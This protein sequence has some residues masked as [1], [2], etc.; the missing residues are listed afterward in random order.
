MPSEK[1]LLNKPLTAEE[2]ARLESYCGNLSITAAAKKLSIGPYT[3]TRAL[4]GKPITYRI[5][6]ILRPI[7]EGGAHE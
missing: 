2:I 7:L 3:Y 5:R 1:I 4:T 6:K